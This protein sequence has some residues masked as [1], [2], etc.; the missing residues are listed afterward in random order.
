MWQY[1]KSIEHE[2]DM[3][4]MHEMTQC[5]FTLNCPPYTIEFTNKHNNKELNSLYKEESNYMLFS[6][7]TTIEDDYRIKINLSHQNYQKKQGELQIA[8]LNASLLY[9]L[10]LLL[11]SGLFAH[12][13]IR[14]LKE[15]LELNDEFVKDILHDFN[16]PI[17]ALKVNFQILQKAF[18]K[19]E[20]I[21]RS[22][23]A[24]NSI[25]DLQSN[26][27]Y[28]LANSQLEQEQVE[29]HSLIGERMNFYQMLFPH[30][31]FHN[32]VSSVKVLI[33]KDAFVR[34]IDNL[35]S[36]AGKYNVIN[37]YVNVNYKNNILEIEDS[38]IGI[39]N[40]K[41]VFER[42]YKETD[43]GIG[44]GLHIVK[45]LCDH[46]NISIQ[47]K[48]KLGKGSSFRLNLNEVMVK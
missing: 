29:L 12:Y 8:V 31:S 36:N 43:R 21:E 7:K 33:N 1:Y 6:M 4:I 46:L 47:V 11:I 45:K 23:Q 9:G 20:A 16:T 25:A 40:P 22:Q 41:S 3:T 15:A 42:F 37:G 30:I 13:S 28:F 17:S 34:I 35:L 10:I 24:M 48:S 19:N 32:N 26:L 38:G 39:K 2:Y 14:P 44:I 27:T 18:G 5:S